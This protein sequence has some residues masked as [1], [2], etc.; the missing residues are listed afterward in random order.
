MCNKQLNYNLHTVEKSLIFWQVI[1]LWWVVLDDHDALTGLLWD[2]YKIDFRE[3]VPRDPTVTH[4]F[5]YSIRKRWWYW[6][7]GSYFLWFWYKGTQVPQLKKLIVFTFVMFFVVFLVSGFLSPIR[8]QSVSFDGQKY[9]FSIFVN[10]S[11]WHLLSKIQDGHWASTGRRDFHKLTKE[12][13][14]RNPR[15]WW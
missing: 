14:P 9:L 12:D 4:Y 5:Y 6:S 7:T 10:S 13:L 1:G 11:L 15:F 8:H 2:K 3:V